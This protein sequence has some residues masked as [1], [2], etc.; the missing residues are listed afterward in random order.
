[1]EEELTQYNQFFE[2]V[3]SDGQQFEK[4][5]DAGLSEILLFV[6]SWLALLQ[7]RNNISE[8]YNS[9][10]ALFNVTQ[11][12]LFR[13]ALWR[14]IA[15]S[16]VGSGLFK[17]IGKIDGY[18][19]SIDKYLG[20][21][22][23]GNVMDRGALLNLVKLS[24]SNLEAQLLTAGIDAYLV[25]PVMA[26]LQ[27]GIVGDVSRAGLIE[28]VRVLLAPG[29]KLN[30]YVKQATN[31][32]VN[33]FIANYQR[34]QAKQIGLAHY[35]YDGVSVADSRPFCLA[36]KGKVFTEQEVESWALKSWE[37]KVPTTTAQSIFVYR[38]GYNCIDHLR[39][40]PEKWY[41]KLKNAEKK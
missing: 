9:Q 22:G 36:R 5:Y 20:K 13:S 40:I 19:G 4:E 7:L 30:Q 28:S 11:L 1:M 2:R 33:G 31:D 38:G 8:T 21:I 25:S 3:A 39:P 18:A 15:N 24:K 12:A 41:E 16:Q 35:L 14:F 26:T 29:A 32:A 6:V 27:S 37:G 23:A 17:A 10:R 34:A